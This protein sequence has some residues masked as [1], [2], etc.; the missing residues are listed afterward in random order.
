M[1]E[2]KTKIIILQLETVVN[3]LFIEFLIFERK[4]IKNL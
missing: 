2:V 3:M 4:N 1:H